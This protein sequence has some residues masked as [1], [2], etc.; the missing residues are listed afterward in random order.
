ME[1]H[2]KIGVFDDASKARHAVEDA[3]SAG[4]SKD[5]IMMA[6][7]GTQPE[8]GEDSLDSITVHP[9]SDT[10]RGHFGG[11]F[12]AAGGA[13]IG[14]YVMFLYSQNSEVLIAGLFV[15]ALAGMALGAGIARILPN[16]IAALFHTKP[17]RLLGGIG[18]AYDTKRSM[19][20]GAIGGTLGALAGTTGSYLLG[21]P[22]LYFFFGSGLY[23]A[24]IS[25]IVGGLV[26]AMSGRGLAPRALGQ[27]ED[28]AD[29]GNNVLVSI[30]CG[31]FQD[32]LAQMDEL[33]RRD[34]AT[35]IRN[36]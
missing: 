34:G 36:A 4:I 1:C 29:G 14:S 19:L 31:T 22:S 5:A 8:S 26:G 11:A 21:I 28:L 18:H 20:A 6:V 16:L 2:Y 23:C 35:M 13:F 33:L 17:Q 10:E 7:A 32:K 27:W 25:L 9:T 12:G 3:M 30:D 15:A 24:V